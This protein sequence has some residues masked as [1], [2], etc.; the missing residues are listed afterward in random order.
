MNFLIRLYPALPVFVLH[1][2]KHIKYWYAMQNRLIIT[3]SLSLLLFVGGGSLTAQTTTLSAQEML[4]VFALQFDLTLPD[5]SFLEME[6]G[7]V[8][9]EAKTES[10]ILCN[11]MPIPFD[12][13]L[14]DTTDMATS[15]E[16]TVL[17]KGRLDFNGTPGY[18]ITMEFIQTEGGKGAEPFLGLMYIRPLNGHTALTINVAYPKAQQERLYPKMLTAFASVH[19]RE[20][21]K[22]Q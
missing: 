2:E 17:H 13:V 8:W 5:T 9:E 14:R 15:P 1:E 19:Q 11:A 16:M 3:S 12:Q 7:A 18:L 22:G 6:P 20:K 10:K 21:G 4:E